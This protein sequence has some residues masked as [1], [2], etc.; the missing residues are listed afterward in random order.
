MCAFNDA[1]TKLLWPEK[2]SGTI[3]RTSE[4]SW[5]MLPDGYLDSR[6]VRWL[7]RNRMRTDP[8]TGAKF[9]AFGPIP[10]GTPV[11]LLA[12][13]DLELNGFVKAW[14]LGRLLIKTA[15]AMKTVRTEN[16]T[17]DAATAELMKLV[18]DLYALNACP[19]F[20][21]D[22]GH[23]FGTNLSDDDKLALIEFLKTF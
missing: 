16:L 9:F 3:W 2:R 22:R 11:N 5:L 21:E 13:T 12:N 18:P 7:L 8:T 17:G 6:I 19:D 23:L 20:V 14:K 1:I 15:D 4:E 10:K